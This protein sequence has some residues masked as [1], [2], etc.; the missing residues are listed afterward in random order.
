MAGFEPNLVV[1]QTI[2][3]IKQKTLRIY[4]RGF[5]NLV[6]LIVVLTGQFSNHFLQDLKKLAS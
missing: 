1:V 2:K 6:S 4:F 3:L 5:L